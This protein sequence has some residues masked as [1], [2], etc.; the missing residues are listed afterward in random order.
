MFALKRIAQGAALAVLASGSALAADLPRRSE[1][2]MAPVYAPP[3]FTWTGFYVGLNAG[4]TIGD[5]RY[6]FA[7]FFSNYA[8]SNVGFTG[9]G[10]LG[11][12]WQMGPVV[13]GAETDINYRSGGSASNGWG[14]GGSNNNSG[15]FGTVRGR[16]GFTPMDRLLIYGTGGLAY[17]NS[18]L[19]NNVVGLDSFGAPRSFYG[20]N[21]NGTKLG[22]TAGAGAEY[23]ITPK[24]SVKA[25]YLYVNLGKTNVN[26]VDAFTGLPGYA[27]ASNR[28]HVVRLGIN[29]H[30]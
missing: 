15:Y 1:A 30:F 11:Y 21:N 9:G 18:N 29:Y 2:P 22:W 28:N 4:A 10:Q 14:N 20:S 13:F 23:A 19:P 16:L 7:P 12:N 27:S 17:G 25:E 5:S 24:W 8:Q 26:Y 3:I 6:Q